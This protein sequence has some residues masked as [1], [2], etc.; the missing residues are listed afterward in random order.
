MHSLIDIARRYKTDKAEHGH[1]LENY[2]RFLGPMR[3]QPV[4]LL[5]L[6]IRDGGSLLM[7][8]DFFP[9]GEIAGLDIMAAAID[10]P[11]GRVHAYVGEQQDTALLDKIAAAHAPEGFDVIID[12]C[13]HIGTLA[14]TSFKHL[15]PN[16]L[17]SGG[18][19][20]VEDWGCGYWDDWPDGVRFRP[21]QLRPQAGM[22]ERAGYKLAS[23]IRN[24]KGGWMTSVLS[25][26][27]QTLVAHNS[28]GHDAGMVGFVK[29][30]LDECAVADVQK[31]LG[32]PDPRP[33]AI[34][35]IHIFASHAF[36]VKS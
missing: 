21:R 33:S 32:L 10:D 4:K 7:W 17:K 3:E 28:A 29:E 11:S 9:E 22:R 15:F 19:Y 35:E 26:I 25:D 5:E 18:I 2:E 6:G 23:I 20:I 30:L 1:Y 27:K 13:S 16:H 8:R 14:R 36:V 31:G 24:S 12:D 34:K